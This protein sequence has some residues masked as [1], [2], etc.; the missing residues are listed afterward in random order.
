MGP[1]MPALDTEPPP[2]FL[3]RMGGR[4]PPGDRIRHAM[5]REALTAPV[6][7]TYK[8]CDGQGVVVA[9]FLRLDECLE[10]I[11]KRM[12]GGGDWIPG[13]YMSVQDY[14]EHGGG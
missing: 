10:Y 11:R 13:E 2:T 7:G 8:V 3:A 5:L 6:P 4:M 9:A 1:L 14:R 12:Q